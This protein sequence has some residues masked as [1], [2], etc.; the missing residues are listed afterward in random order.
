MSELK[1]INNLIRDQEF[2]ALK[3]VKIPVKK[4]SFLIDKI[5]EEEGSKM[6]C[7]SV[8]NATRT[9]VRNGAAYLNADEDIFQDNTDTE[10]VHDMS[11]PETQ[12]LLIRTLSIGQT[13]RSQNKE[14]REFLDSMDKDLS[15]I[16]SSTRTDRE[17]LDEVISVLTNKSVYPLVPPRK[18]QLDGT[19]CGITWK[20]IIII[21]IL[22]GVIPLLGYLSY[23]VY[24]HYN[25]SGS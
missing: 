14:A 10:S 11:D 24:I 18:S 3:T 21:A 13:S 12:K 7:D 1:R 16:Q 20:T 23:L 9:K 6:V 15:R 19:D 22:V 17:S 5:S 25:K 4:H 8:E 2:F